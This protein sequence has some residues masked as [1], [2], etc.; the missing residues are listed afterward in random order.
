L[1]SI[2]KLSPRSRRQKSK[3]K[4]SERGSL[5]NILIMQLRKCLCHPFIYSQAIEDRNTSLEVARRNMIEASAK[6]MLLEIM[7]PKL[8]EHVYGVLIFSQFLDQLIVLEDFLAGLGLRHERLD[9]LQSSMEKQKKI[10]AF[11][12]PDSDLFAVLL[13]TCRSYRR[14]LRSGC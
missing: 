4:S 2:T 6:L 7:L 8:K 12:A 9:G 14:W 13:S 5:S 3:I 10:D 1:L 11:N